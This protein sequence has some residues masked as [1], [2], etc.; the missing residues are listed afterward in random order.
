MSSGRSTRS[1]YRS[2]LIEERI[3]KLFAEGTMLVDV[4]GEP[5]GQVNGLSVLDLGDIAFG[6][7]EPHHR[8][9]RAGPAGVIDIEREAKLGRADPHTR[10]C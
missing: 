6:T 2:N 9:H 8:E 3:Q 1:V 7:A 4:A 10:A 5:V